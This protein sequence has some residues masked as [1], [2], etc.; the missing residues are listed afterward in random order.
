MK[1]LHLRILSTFV[2]IFVLFSLV[3]GFFL[4]NL[5]SEH[6]RDRQSDAL[7]EQARLM[8]FFFAENM[9]GDTNTSEIAYPFN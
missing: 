3:F 2:I 9:E 5:L 6:S 7:I 1:Q 8:S 4:N